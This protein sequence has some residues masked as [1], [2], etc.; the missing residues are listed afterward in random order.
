M[1]LDDDLAIAATAIGVGADDVRTGPGVAPTLLDGSGA[2]Q[3]SARQVG[4]GDAPVG[5]PARGDAAGN[6]S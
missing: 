5:A 2:G 3:I 4:R 6:R 1:P